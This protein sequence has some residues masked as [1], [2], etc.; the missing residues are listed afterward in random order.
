MIERPDVTIV[1]PV[2]NHSE[3]L[4]ECLRSVVAQT[5]AGWE[6]I[7]VDDGS[8]SGDVAAIG[9]SIGDGRISVIR[10]DRNRGLAAARNTGIRAGS[11]EFVLPLDADD[12]LA[13]TFLEETRGALRASPCDAAFTDFLAF[14]VRTGVL[15]YRV[16]DVRA[17]LTDQWIPGPGTLFRRTLYEAAGG[18]CEADELRPGNEDWDFWLSAAAHGLRATHVPR[19]LYLYRQHVASMVTR[20]QYHD[21]STRVFIS[22]RHRSLFD[23]YGLTNAFLSDGSFSSA[24]ASWR[25]H[26]RRRAVRLGVRSFL[27]S[28]AGCVRSVADPTIRQLRRLARQTVEVR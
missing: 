25:K 21:Y 16:R 20:L 4:V 7:V 6:A 24:K 2:Y 12:K 28:P 11:G 3:F 18:Y 1:V 22:E 8:V 5:V 15:P 23:R 10:H 19:P 9:R 17:L 27:L 14:G 13:P 26:E